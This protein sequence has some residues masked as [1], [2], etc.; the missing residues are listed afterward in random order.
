MYGLLLENVAEVIRMNYGQSQWDEIKQRAEVTQLQFVN[1]QAYSET[2]MH[3]ICKAASEILDLSRDELMYKFG[4]T[5]VHQMT[6]KGYRDILRVLG[7]NVRDFVNGLDNLHEY[8]KF[9][10]PKLKP[11]SFIVT[12]E[13]FAGITLEYK[14]KR[15]GFTYYVKGQLEAVC[16]EFY[17]TNVMIDILSENIVSDMTNISYRMKFDNTLSNTSDDARPRSSLRNDLT[18]SN[19]LF[20][21]LFPFNV[22]FNENMVIVAVG[23]SLKTIMDDAQGRAID[24]VFTLKKPPITLTYNN[25]RNHLN[26][27]FELST[28]DNVGPDREEQ[29]EGSNGLALRGQMVL[30]VEWQVIVYLASPILA[31]LE[32]MKRAGLFINDLCMHD[33]SREL[34]LAGTQQ[35]VEMKLA[36]SQ[37]EQKARQLEQNLKTLDKEMKK[38]D[39]LLYQM[40]PKSIAQQLRRGVS[41][42]DTCK[43][44]ESVSIVFTDIKGFTKIC[45]PLKPTDVVKLLN[46]MYTLFDRFSD[47]HNIFKVETI[48]DA[49]M[50]VGGCPNENQEHPVNALEM[51]LHMVMATGMITTPNGDNLQIRAGVHSGSAIAGIVGMTMPRYCLFGKSVQIANLMESS[52]MPD[53]VQVSEDTKKLL[54]KTTYIFEKRQDKIQFLEREM[55]TYFVQRPLMLDEKSKREYAHVQKLVRDTEADADFTMAAD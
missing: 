3:R 42:V 6:K 15:R 45:S 32:D 46:T 37:E 17:N 16:R 39:D 2:Y 44:Y 34:V 26:N 24:E 31:N 52:G 25:V 11:P 21:Y 38:T 41:P 35:S 27:V 22:V 23:S 28:M 1:H 10:Y 36:L 9:S 54:S 50:G 55:T 5:F 47:Q 43:L 53:R 8:L 18:I 49:Y 7:R 48:G 30:M 12:Q 51:A 33:S 40:I 14:S 19:S 29:E 20:F 13:D 4:E